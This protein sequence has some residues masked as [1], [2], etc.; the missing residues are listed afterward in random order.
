MQGILLCLV[1]DGDFRENQCSRTKLAN[2]D[3]NRCSFIADDRLSLDPLGP[4]E[5]G[6][7]IVE[8]SHVASFQTVTSQSWLSCVRIARAISMPSE[9]EPIKRAGKFAAI[10]IS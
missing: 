7:R 4:V 6:N 3:A 5:G 8:G 2:G 9:E 10:V 1:Q